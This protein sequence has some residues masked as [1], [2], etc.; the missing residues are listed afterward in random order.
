[1]VYPHTRLV[2]V[3]SLRDTSRRRETVFSKLRYESETRAVTFRCYEY[4]GLGNKILYQNKCKGYNFIKYIRMHI[5]E[6]QLKDFILD[7]DLISQ[8]D[9]EKA[10]KKANAEGLSIGKVLVD[11]GK[12]TD[13]DLR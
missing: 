9:L 7:S 12:I 8:S 5:E 4:T 11:Q 3:V 6:A 1:M 13:D 2:I 10:E